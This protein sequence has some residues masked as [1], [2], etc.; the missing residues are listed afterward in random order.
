MFLPAV[1]GTWLDGRLGTRFCGPTGLVLGFVMG[2]SW[3]VSL[4][5]GRRGR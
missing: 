2:L 5:G 4:G 3:L 1:A